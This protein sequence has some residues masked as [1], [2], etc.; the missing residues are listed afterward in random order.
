MEQDNEKN[1]Q[2]IFIEAHSWWTDVRTTFYFSPVDRHLCDGDFEAL[3][4]VQ[5][6][7]I[8]GPV[9]KNNNNKCS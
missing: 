8:K 4:D 2:Q 6:L 9:R 7:H 1:I 5:K 3:G